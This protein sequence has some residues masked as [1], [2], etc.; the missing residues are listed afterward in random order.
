MS[1][2]KGNDS[3]D[4]LPPRPDGKYWNAN[5][6]YS[7]DIIPR[8]LELCE[9]GKSYNQVSAELKIPMSTMVD[10]R[11]RFP[12][13]LQAWEDGRTLA[14]A[15]WEKKIHENLI[16]YEV[17]GEP[18]K[19]FRSEL[20]LYTMRARFKQKEESSTTINKDGSMTT[21][22]TGE[23]LNILTQKYMDKET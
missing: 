3:R 4:D 14:M 9:M 10:W 7:P 17:K 22:E 13:F 20:A 23:A 11:K 6:T 19:V 18:K 8:F 12:D 21:T 1:F 15:H 2:E 5:T 16:D